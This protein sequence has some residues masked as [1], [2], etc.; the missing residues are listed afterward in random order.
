MGLSLVNI[1]SR[2][3]LFILLMCVCVCVSGEIGLRSLRAIQ[4]LP[5]IKHIVNILSENLGAEAKDYYWI[6][7][8]LP[9]STHAHTLLRQ[10]INNINILLQ[11]IA[12]LLL[13]ITFFVLCIK[14][15]TACPDNICLL[16]SLLKIKG[17]KNTKR[18]CCVWSH[19]EKKKMIRSFWFLICHFLS[20]VFLVIGSFRKL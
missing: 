18:G 2:S 10:K 1:H 9:P 11:L 3:V 8:L 19:F 5:F 6:C 20:M 17:G 13:L 7:G 16:R 12:E 15:N 14:T 4:S